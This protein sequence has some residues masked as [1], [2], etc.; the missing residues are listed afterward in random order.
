VTTG[1]PTIDVF[2]SSAAMEPANA[3]AH[4]SEKL[5]TL[6]GIGTRYRAPAAPAD[7]ARS[8]FGLPADAPLLLCPQS[9]FKIH[10]DNDALFAR[11]LEAVPGALLVG[12]EGRDPALTAKFRARLAR[13]GIGEHRLR[14]LPQ[15]AHDDFLRVNRVCDVMLD[16]LHWSGGNTSLD[17]IACALPMITLPGRFMRGRQSMAMLTLMGVDELVAAD[18]DDYVRKVAAIA[19]DRSRRDDIS[20]RMAAARDAVFDDAAPIAALA[21]FLAA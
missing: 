3:Q 13:A 6:P 10:P 15:C 16:T 19:A 14:L 11:V 20:R 9:L 5:V 12:F 17:A 1:L 2:F 7:A 4:Y 8:R 21:Q 18:E